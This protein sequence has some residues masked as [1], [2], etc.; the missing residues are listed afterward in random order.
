MQTTR[1][2]DPIDRH[3]GSC[4]ELLRMG[5]RLHRRARCSSGWGG[6]R[7]SRAAAVPGK[8]AGGRWR[9]TPCLRQVRDESGHDHGRLRF[10]YISTRGIVC[11]VLIRMG[12]SASARRQSCRSCRSAVPRAAAAAAAA[13]SCASVPCQRATMTRPRPRPPLMMTPTL[14]AISVMPVPDLGQTAVLLRR[15][16]WQ[17]AGTAHQ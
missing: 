10:P 15:R 8:V 3:A 13:A 16:G 5:T 7:F 12:A 2:G 4:H 9:C 6:R 11:S 1:H 17:M 14:C